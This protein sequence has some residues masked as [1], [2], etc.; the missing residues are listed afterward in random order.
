MIMLSKLLFVVSVTG[1]FVRSHETLLLCNLPS[2]FGKLKIYI[3]KH[4]CVIL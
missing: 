4:D 1:K 3:M 2:S